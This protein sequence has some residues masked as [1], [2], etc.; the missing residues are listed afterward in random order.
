MIIVAKSVFHEGN[1]F[2]PQVFFQDVCINWNM[3][4]KCYILIELMFVNESMSKRKVNG[5]II[6]QYWYFFKVLSFNQISAMGDTMC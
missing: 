4:K 5:V 3:Y 2:Y 1:K 6:R